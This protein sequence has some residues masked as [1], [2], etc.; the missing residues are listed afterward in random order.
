M[1]WIG[2]RLR[3][4]VR[5]RPDLDRG[6]AGLLWSRLLPAYDLASA[7]SIRRLDGRGLDF[8]RLRVRLRV[9]VHLLLECLSGLCRWYDPTCEPLDV[10]FGSA[11]LLSGTSGFFCPGFNGISGRIDS[12]SFLLL[13]RVFSLV[14]CSLGDFKS[15]VFFLRP[16]D[17]AIKEVKST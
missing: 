4:Y 16:M 6:D 11:A 12:S 8:D 7:S 3:R 15:L 14:I 2:E 10:C 1:R 17:D 13:D 9:T 5:E